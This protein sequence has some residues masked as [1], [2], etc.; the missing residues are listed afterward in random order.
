MSYL[1][2]VGG[3][4]PSQIH[5]SEEEFVQCCN[6]ARGCTSQGCQGGQADEVGKAY[7]LFIAV[8]CVN[9]TPIMNLATLLYLYTAVTLALGTKEIYVIYAL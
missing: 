1:Q 6:R 5:F 9:L 2:N 4:S 7:G 3:I 8:D